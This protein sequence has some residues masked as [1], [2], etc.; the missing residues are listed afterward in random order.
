[1]QTVSTR[2]ELRAALQQARAEGR[3]VG[4]V[5]TMGYLHDGHLSLI[6]RAR[7]ECE[8]VV[9]SIFVNP[10]QFAAGE[11]LDTYPRDPEGDAASC[12]ELGVDLLWM[13]TKEQMYRPDHATSIELSGLANTLCGKSRPTHFSGVATIVTK[14]LNSVR[15]HRVYMGQKDYQQLA[16]IRA[17]VLDLDMDVEVIGLP[18]VREPD[19]VA[20]SSRNA[21]LSAEGRQA[22]VQIPQSLAAIRRQYAEAAVP[23]ADS[24]RQ[25]LRAS[26]EAAPGLKIDYA[27]VVDAHTLQAPAP[28]SRELLAA[29]AVFSGDVRLIDNTRLDEPDEFLDEL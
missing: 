21:R 9:V 2:S 28:G 12:R 26:L 1:M 27:E 25:S 10:T 13:P 11:D 24:L 22:A 20:M 5:P 3:S 15:P 18:T 14:L 4:F 19:G 17:M 29:V 23:D 7:R 6:R 16:I 8:L